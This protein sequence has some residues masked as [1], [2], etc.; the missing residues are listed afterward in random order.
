MCSRLGPQWDAIGGRDPS[1]AEHMEAL[2]DGYGAQASCSCMSELW[3]EKLI[4][5]C[6]LSHHRHKVKK[7]TSHELEP[8]TIHLFSLWVTICCNLPWKLR[9]YKAM[10]EQSSLGE[11]EW[12]LLNSTWWPCSTGWCRASP[13]PPCIN[14]AE[15]TQIIPYSSNQNTYCP[16]LKLEILQ[17]FVFLF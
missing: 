1:K 13:P 4:T 6:L 17:D 7:P 14:D 11:A 15:R 8:W 12:G 9:A 5:M 3:G 10:L 16:I 2:D